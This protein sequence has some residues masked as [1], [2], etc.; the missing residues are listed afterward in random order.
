[1]CF[2]EGITNVRPATTTSA[3]TATT[4]TTTTTVKTIPKTI[5]QSKPTV[6]TLSGITP[7]A[8]T[9]SGKS[10]STSETTAPPQSGADNANSIQ[11]DDAANSVSSSFQSPL[12]NTTTT[13]QLINSFPNSGAQSSPTSSPALQ[14]RINI[15]NSSS[16]SRNITTVSGPTLVQKLQSMTTTTTTSSTANY[17]VLS[18]Q[19]P[20]QQPQSI[21]IKPSTTTTTNPNPNRIVITKTVST[22]APS[23]D[24]QKKPITSLSGKVADVIRAPTTQISLTPI[25]NSANLN[26]IGKIKTSAFLNEL[27]KVLSVLNNHK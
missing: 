19:L 16:P 23:S 12:K 1:M 14:Q 5:I 4:T 13:F 22:I 3:A 20:Q 11:P 24:D 2:K 7:I 26:A 10:I 25:A 6:T 17:K 21:V 9:T 27:E 8:V 15:S 18:Q